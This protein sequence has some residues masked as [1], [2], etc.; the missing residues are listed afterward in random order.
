[1]R[2]PAGEL[3]HDFGLRFQLAAN[4]PPAVGIELQFLD[5]GFG[6]L[7]QL[8]RFQVFMLGLDG[9][10]ALLV[11][12]RDTAEIPLA[13]YICNLGE[14]HVGAVPGRTHHNIPEV[15]HDLAFFFN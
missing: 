2:H 7:Q 1:M 10:A 5:K 14:R 12:P 6:G 8:W 3:S 9:H 11:A 13:A 15:A 4:L